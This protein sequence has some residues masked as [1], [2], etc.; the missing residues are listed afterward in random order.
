MITFNCGCKY[1]TGRDKT[2]FKLVDCGNVWCEVLGDNKFAMSN[3]I[4]VISWLNSSGELIRID[5]ETGT[6]IQN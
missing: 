2:L 6:K 3:G 4:K 5:K 1:E